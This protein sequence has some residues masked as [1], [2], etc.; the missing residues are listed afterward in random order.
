[1]KGVIGVAEGRRSAVEGDEREVGAVESRGAAER[2]GR[3][4]GRRARW[5]RWLSGRE[6][7]R[8]EPASSRAGG[9]RGVLRRS[10]R[11]RWGHQWAQARASRARGESLAALDAFGNAPTLF[12][13]RRAARAC[14]GGVGGGE[15]GAGRAK[16]A[17]GESARA[18]SERK[19][20][21]LR[22]RRRGR[23][24]SESRGG[25]ESE[26]GRGSSTATHLSRP[27]PPRRPHLVHRKIQRLGAKLTTKEEGRRQR[28][29][30]E[31]EDEVKGTESRREREA[32]GIQDQGG[33]EGGRGGG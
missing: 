17:D 30:Q 11:Q 1:M 10:V 22:A 26:G 21:V 27:S 31:G 3:S 24:Q 12:L 19:P 18:R 5:R 2:K 14:G 16:A 13:A 6:R 32:E 25:D 15:G 8:A 29:K 4:I 23:G 33:T 20:A 7:R 28:R 9:R